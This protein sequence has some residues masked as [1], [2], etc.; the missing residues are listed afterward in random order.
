M[1]A[2]DTNSFRTFQGHARPMGLN[3]TSF[4]QRLRLPMATL[5]LGL[6]AALAI[7]GGALDT[8]IGRQ[9]IGGLTDV[10]YL[11]A[12]LPVTEPAPLQD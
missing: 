5:V 4:R 11:T 3:E 9:V 10:E 2:Q 12:P 1:A 6:M 7:A 8:L